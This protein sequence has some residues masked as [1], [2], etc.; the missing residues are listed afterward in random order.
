MMHGQ[1]QYFMKVQEKYLNDYNKEIK[2]SNGNI[3]KIIPSEDVYR[4]R[5]KI[6]KM[7]L[8]TK[9]CELDMKIN[10]LNKR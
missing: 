1:I 7:Y 10:Y 8:F 3:I 9:D 5:P 6:I 4:S 2:L